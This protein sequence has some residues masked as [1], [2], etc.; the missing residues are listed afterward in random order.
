[1]Q[2]AQIFGDSK[3]TGMEAHPMK[4]KKVVLVNNSRLMHDFIK[5]VI[6]K[7]EGLE[8]T[9]SIQN[10]DNLPELILDTKADLAIVLLPPGEPAPDTLKNVINKHPST[11]FLLMGM[12][13]SRAR[14]KWNEPHEVP[15]D[16]MSLQELLVM[17]SDNQPERI[18]I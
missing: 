12:D 18:E 1:M 4:E 10:L 13:G 9:A 17:L 8:F 6:V 15:L 2:K 7:T 5:K 16:E 11:R 3:Y 14:L